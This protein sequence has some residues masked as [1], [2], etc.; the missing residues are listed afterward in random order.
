[1]SHVGRLMERRE[2]I[3]Q[4]LEEEQDKEKEKA[5]EDAKKRPDEVKRMKGNE[6]QICDWEREIEDDR[7]EHSGEVFEY[8]TRLGTVES[9]SIDSVYLPQG[10]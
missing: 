10:L 3:H 4:L 6:R 9:H 1:M 2:N 8:I 5:R 7:G